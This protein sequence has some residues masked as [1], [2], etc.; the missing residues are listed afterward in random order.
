MSS[1][2]LP[3]IISKKAVLSSKAIA[4]WRRAADLAVSRSAYREAASHLRRALALL[5]HVPADRAR[6]EL[7]LANRLGVM[8]FILEGG[9]SPTARTIYERNAELSETFEADRETF[10]ALW[11]L[12]Y[13]DYISGRTAS[14]QEKA[15]V[16]VGVAERLHD[17]DLL[18]EALHARWA[19]AFFMGDVRTTIAAAQHG[20]TIY[21]TERHHV[22]VTTFGSGHDSGVCCLTHGALGYYL[23]GQFASGDAWLE[24]GL[25]LARRLDHPFSLCHGF[26]TAS[27][28]LDFIGDY[29]RAKA[30]AA[31]CERT[32]REGK[33]LMSQAIGILVSGAAMIGS[34]ETDVGMQRMMSVLDV[35]SGPD[36]AGWRPFYLTRLANALIERGDLGHARERMQQA[37]TRLAATGGAFGDSEVPRMLATLARAEGGSIE[38]VLDQLERAVN[39]AT[40]TG[41]TLLQMRALADIVELEAGQRSLEARADIALPL[42]KTDGGELLPDIRRARSL[43]R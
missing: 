6:L 23:S 20:A 34:G 18:L 9:M 1:R 15:T 38:L 19:A 22:H 12:C 30:H 40:Q 5:D 36:P 14:A 2:K 26:Q 28:A 7:E 13:S 8:H 21:S 43:V 3:P 41:S 31:E 32:A 35:T 29:E 16:L 33:F 11:G 4:Y 25:T 10:A 24:K 39:R 37:Q 42:G 17:D 27:L